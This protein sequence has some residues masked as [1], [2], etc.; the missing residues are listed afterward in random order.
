MK[1][2]FMKFATM[3]AA[4][5]FVLASCEKE[6]GNDT[7]NGG[8]KDP[9]Q[10]QP[11]N[12]NNQG[13]DNNNNNG[14][15]TGELHASLQGSEY[16]T[17]SLD[18]YSTAA[19]QN[20]IKASYQLDDTN[21]FLYVWENTYAA[22]TPSGL[23]FYGEA[24][25]WSS[26]VVGNVGWSGCGWCVVNP[27]TVPA[28]VENAADFANWKFHIGYKGQ[29]GKAHIVILYWNGGDYKF[30]IGEGSLDDAGISYTAIAPTSGKFQPNVWN[31]YEISLAETGLDFTK[32]TT[33]NLAAVLSGGAAGTT[34][35]VDAIFFY[36][37]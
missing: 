4:A 17:I 10:E 32:S 34:L 7:G 8:L 11:G 1:K 35:D 20:K 36:K 31:E 25:G 16:V 19:I 37:K 29:A 3:F 9:N 23:N 24:T 30:A 22:G 5:M 27:A 21:V 13:G 28:F 33:G 26:L 14:G 6:G 15:S 18:E 12:N 2:S